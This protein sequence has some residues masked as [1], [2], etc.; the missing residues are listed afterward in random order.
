MMAEPSTPRPSPP[1]E[2]PAP[3][4]API[5]TPSAPSAPPIRMTQGMVPNSRFSTGS[6]WQAMAEGFEA[7]SRHGAP[8]ALAR[9]MIAAGVP[10]RPV[11]V[12]TFP[13]DG[14]NPWEISYRSLAAMAG[15]TFTEGIVTTLQEVRYVEPNFAW[16]SPPFAAGLAMDVPAADE[17]NGVEP[18]NDTGQDSGAVRAAP[19]VQTR[20]LKT[21]TELP[22]NPLGSAV[23]LVRCEL[24]G[25]TPTTANSRRA[26]DETPAAAPQPPVRRPGIS[27]RPRRPAPQHGRRP[28]DDESAASIGTVAQSA[29]VADGSIPHNSPPGRGELRPSERR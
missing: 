21:L 12:E 13:P 14:G 7:V 18:M 23:A 2:R 25:P 20:P 26:P 16:A 3:A 19:G 11:I 17:R 22:R 29:H 8:Q 27:S 6:A 5:S 10:D 9:Q 4:P 15:R 1:P 28:V 24:S